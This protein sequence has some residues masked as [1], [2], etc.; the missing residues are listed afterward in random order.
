MIWRYHSRVRAFILYY[1]NGSN[2]KSWSKNNDY[3]SILTPELREIFGRMKLGASC[4]I[5]IMNRIWNTL[6]MLS[7]L[8]LLPDEGAIVGARV[9]AEKVIGAVTRKE[10]IKRTLRREDLIA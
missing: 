7:E 2:S 10:R 1:T 9:D 6:Q 3:K 4:L 5:E 8:K